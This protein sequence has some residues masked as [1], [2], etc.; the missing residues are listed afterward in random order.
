MH[1]RHI[2]VEDIFPVDKVVDNVEK[3]QKVPFSEY[4]LEA[5][6]KA[7]S[8]DVRSALVSALMVAHFYQLMPVTSDP[9]FNGDPAR[10]TPDTLQSCLKLSD[11]KG[12]KLPATKPGPLAT[13]EPPLLDRIV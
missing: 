8:D 2:L 13:G 12:I 4:E 10:V 3:V 6:E 7:E 5:I 1:V 11:P 9:I